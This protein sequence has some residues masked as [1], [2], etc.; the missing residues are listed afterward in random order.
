MQNN[1]WYIKKATYWRLSSIDLFSFVKMAQKRL[2]EDL[3]IIENPGSTVEV[4]CVVQSLS[5]MKKAKS[6]YRIL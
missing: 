5:D 4:H 6:G 3:L 2:Y 1:Y